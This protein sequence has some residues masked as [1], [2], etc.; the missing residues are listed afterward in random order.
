MDPNHS[1]AQKS[2]QRYVNNVFPA[3]I[4]LPVT[5]VEAPQ[6]FF[7]DNVVETGVVE[8]HGMCMEMLLADENMDM[9]GHDYPFGIEQQREVA[10]TAVDFYFQR[11]SRRDD[12][13]A[14]ALAQA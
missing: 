13:W 7:A 1:S 4:G 8:K 10:R 9:V 3:A 5:F 11:H 2:K 12:E 14:Y 6:E